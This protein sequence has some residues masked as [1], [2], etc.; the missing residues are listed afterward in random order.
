MRGWRSH[1]LYE[2]IESVLLGPVVNELTMTFG[3]QPVP[4]VVPVEVHRL[5]RSDRTWL[6]GLVHV[7]PGGGLCVGSE[8][9]LYTSQT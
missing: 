8:S 1:Q 5:Q 6:R 9:V 4:A 7:D 3:V 2:A